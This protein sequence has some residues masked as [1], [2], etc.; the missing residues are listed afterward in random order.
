MKIL[1]IAAALLI[2]TNSMH[3]NDTKQAD[4]FRQAYAAYKEA[5]QSGDKAG[6]RDNAA[7]AYRLGLEIF[8][9]RHK[10]SASL[11]LIYGRLLTGDAAEKV[12][13]HALKLHENVY[14]KEAL[15]LIDPLMDLA[16]TQAD[17]RRLGAARRYYNRALK[18]A[19]KQDLENDY[20]LGR[21]NLEIG[22][23]ALSS[24]N[25][26]EAIRF[27][28]KA[29]KIFAGLE[30]AEIELAQ[31]RFWI[32]KYRL[33][34]GKNKSATEKLEASLATFEKLI[35]DSSMTMTNHAFLIRAYEKRGQRDEATKH[36][37]AIGATKP[38]DPK[39][40][41]MPVY[42]VKPTYPEIPR[43]IG[44]EGYV[45]VSLTVDA[46]GFVKDPAAIEREGSKLFEKS[47]LEA[48]EQFRYVPRFENGQPVATHNVKYKFSF[49][50][51][52]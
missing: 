35:P 13:R 47:A 18:I 34:I 49:H 45:I 37:L 2:A 33:A 22:Q 20:F 9:E 38:H 27:L 31:T 3:A 39:Q 4:E 40:N 17:F 50:V 5:S 24:S 23:V 29:E 41:F 16:R 28:D 6:E 32:G 48:L 11:A 44:Q 43:R 12:L 19:K 42:S 15:N 10:N 25:S 30:G 7:D 51:E 21:L 26:S 8:G 1:A 46:N 52:Y 36:C 14:G